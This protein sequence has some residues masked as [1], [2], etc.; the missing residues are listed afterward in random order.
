[1]KNSVAGYSQFA[2]D[3]LLAEIFTASTGCCLE[4]GAFDG[5]IGST[6]LAFE[7]RGWTAILVEPLPWLATQAKA[8]RRGPVYV[9]AAGPATGRVTLQ[10]AHEDPAV[11]G[12]VGNR[13]QAEMLRIRKIT[14]ES[15]EV[16]QLTIDFILEECAVEKLDFATID[17]EGF[18]AQVLAG[19]SLARWKPRIVILEDN[20]R[21]LDPIV[22]AAMAQ[23]GYLRFRTTGVNDWYARADNRQ[24]V[25][26]IARAR[27]AARVYRERLRAIAKRRAPAGIRQFL[28]RLGAGR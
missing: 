17:V 27:D 8:R 11:S 7:Q 25:T 28:R 14:L 23:Q 10:H 15:I 2:E 18:E 24:L 19:F 4:V 9:A 3:A 16:P 12:V 26:P 13:Y 1:M 6:T 21:G 5:V 20:S 22:P